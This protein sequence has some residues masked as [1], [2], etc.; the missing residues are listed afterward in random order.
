MTSRTLA[1]FA[2]GTSFPVGAAPGAR[3]PPRPAASRS[4]GRRN[5][6][7]YISGLRLYVPVT[8]RVQAGSSAWS[9]TFTWS[10]FDSVVL[11]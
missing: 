9:Q 2:T 7:A 3:R 8:Y 6:V 4:P 5:Y 10:S 1:A 11:G